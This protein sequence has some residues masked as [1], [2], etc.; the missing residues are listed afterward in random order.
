M[1]R[2][3]KVWHVG[4]P[5]CCIVAAA[6]ATQA[7]YMALRWGLW[8]PHTAKYTDIRSTRLAIYDA[9]A[10]ARQHPCFLAQHTW[11]GEFGLEIP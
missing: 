9:H 7:R 6:T 10:A 1:L 8:L 3:W 5:G 4:E 2:A 11:L